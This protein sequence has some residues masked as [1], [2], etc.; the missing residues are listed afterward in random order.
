MHV[1]PG[2][3]LLRSVFSSDLI[4]YRHCGSRRRSGRQYQCCSGPAHKPITSRPTREIMNDRSRYPKPLE[5]YE[6]LNFLGPNLVGTEGSE[7]WR[8][9]RAA[10]P[11]FVEKNN[12]LMWDEAG[13]IVQKMLCREWKCA[14]KFKAPNS[15]DITVPV[16]FVCVSPQRLRISWADE[17]APVRHTRSLKKAVHIISSN[18]FRRFL[19][20]SWAV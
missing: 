14:P 6:H 9:R 7:W 12:R 16:R 11:A 15:V 17:A 8:H 2:S 1:S 13:P 20:P 5:A 18:P 4:Q 3:Q 10:A 19:F